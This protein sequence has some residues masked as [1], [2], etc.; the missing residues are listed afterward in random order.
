MTNV[1]SD[2]GAGNT[3]LESYE[4]MEEMIDDVGKLFWL[5]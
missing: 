4:K 5:V 1:M 3:N 2:F